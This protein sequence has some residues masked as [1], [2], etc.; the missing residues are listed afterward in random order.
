MNHTTLSAADIFRVTVQGGPRDRITV[1]LEWLDIMGA[2][3][4]EHAEI[5]VDTVRHSLDTGSVKTAGR[6]PFY[7]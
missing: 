1:A 4:A 5:L 6:L 7:Y 3:S 2:V